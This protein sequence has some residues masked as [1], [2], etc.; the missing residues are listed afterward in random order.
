MAFSLAISRTISSS[1]HPVI[2][3]TSI[4]T[5]TSFAALFHRRSE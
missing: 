3:R 1:R 5:L 2:G 4:S